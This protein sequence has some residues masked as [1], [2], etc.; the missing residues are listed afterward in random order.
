MITTPKTDFISVSE[1]R[2]FSYCP[3]VVWHGKWLGLNRPVTFKMKE[4][5]DEEAEQARLELR[6]NFSAYGIIAKGKIFN[7]YVYSE[8]LKIS[9]I[10]D[11]L[12]ELTGIEFADAINSCKTFDSQIFIPVEKKST[13]EKIGQHQILQLT[14]YGMLIEEMTGS[15]VNYGFMVSIPSNRVKKIDF[16]KELR[17]KVVDITDEISN[18]LTEG[19]LPPP[20]PHRGKC[21]DCEFKRFCNDVW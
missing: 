6:R 15:P 21:Q 10:L 14:A 9:G 8:K 5:Q 16:T 2:Q 17:Q 18:M 13:E 20:T 11:M 19:I 1:L 4:G 3:R 12:I 7:L